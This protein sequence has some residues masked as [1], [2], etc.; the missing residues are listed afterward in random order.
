MDFRSDRILITGASGFTGRIL[1]DRLRSEGASVFGLGRAAAGPDEIA[2]DL[3]DSDSLRRAIQVAR[4]TAVVHLAGVTHATHG[5]VAEVYQS[6]VTGTAALLSAIRDH[7]QPRVVILASSA[8]VYAPPI[9]DAPIAEDAA[10]VPQS[11]YGASKMAME[12]VARLFMPSLPIVVTRPFNYTGAGQ[13]PSFLVPKIVDHFIRGERAIELGNL[14][15]YRDFSDVR[16]IVEAYL[17]LLATPPIGQTL[18]LCSGRAVHLSSV[19][20]HM[21]VIAGYAIDVTINPAFVRAGEPRT[22]VGSTQRMDTTVG[23]L[24]PPPFIDTLRSMYE[25]GKDRR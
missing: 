6:N 23:A 5:D 11:H 17:V 9:D 16:T 14:D 3:N 8:T 22:I 10:Q 18:N 2:G 12:Q 24:R 1:A 15:L 21:A 25:T 4:P 7:A 13:A 20:E 19:L